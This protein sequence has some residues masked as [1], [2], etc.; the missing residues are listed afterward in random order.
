MS[1]TLGYFAERGDRGDGFG[2]LGRGGAGG[3]MEVRL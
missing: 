3:W 1:K 2:F